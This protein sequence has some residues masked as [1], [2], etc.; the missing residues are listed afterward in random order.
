[1]YELATFRYPFPAKGLWEIQ[2]MLRSNR[3]P[4]PFTNNSNI[5]EDF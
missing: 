2:D 4:D 3:S 5:S 1:M